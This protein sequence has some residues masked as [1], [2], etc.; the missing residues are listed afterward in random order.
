METPDTAGIGC[1]CNV[2]ELLPGGLAYDEPKTRNLMQ[3]TG[4]TSLRLAP[5]PIQPLQ[6]SANR[7]NP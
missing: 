2:A 3:A 6:L 4:A 5:S 1:T 7:A